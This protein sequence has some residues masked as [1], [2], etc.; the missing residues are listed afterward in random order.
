[1]E[2]SLWKWVS[3]V[4]TAGKLV[5]NH[6]WDL[7]RG[8]DTIFSNGFRFSNFNYQ[9]M[10]NFGKLL[11]NSNCLKFCSKLTTNIYLT[12]ENTI[13]FVPCW[14][15]LLG[16]NFKQFLNEAP[17][18]PITLSSLRFGNSCNALFTFN[19]TNKQ[20]NKYFCCWNFGGNVSSLLATN[21]S[22]EVLIK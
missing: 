3:E 12:R 16:A 11:L 22:M 6:H 21:Q 20:I 5:W 9:I 2:G 10:W 13:P 4:E 8:T 15:G 18:Y 7:T 19:P 1:M 14:S 17:L